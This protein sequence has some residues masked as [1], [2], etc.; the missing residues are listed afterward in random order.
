MGY[1]P[2]GAELECLSQCICDSP[3]T[4][5]VTETFTKKPRAEIALAQCS[6]NANKEVFCLGSDPLI[7]A[8]DS[9]AKTFKFDTYTITLMCV[10]AA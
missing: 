7:L 10:F 8:D 5:D 1:K 6:I 9:S 3:I 4:F 2:F